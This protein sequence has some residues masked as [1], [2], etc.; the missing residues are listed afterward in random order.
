[1]IPPI[2]YRYFRPRPGR[3]ASDAA[4]VY[5]HLFSDDVAGSTID[6]VNQMIPTFD[7]VRESE[8]EVRENFFVEQAAQEL[9]AHV[10]LFTLPLPIKIGLEVYSF[11]E[12]F[13][14]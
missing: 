6:N 10:F 4:R 13:N 12:Y 8:R 1:M 9:A 7:D 2:I 11:Y 3:V 5:Y 14:E